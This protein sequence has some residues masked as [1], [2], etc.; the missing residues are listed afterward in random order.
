MKLKK[1][2]SPVSSAASSSPSPIP[3]P[4]K[5]SIT[6]I[7]KAA[8]SIKTA[9]KDKSKV[10]VISDSTPAIPSSTPI[11]AI[12][13]NA[14]L[15]TVTKIPNNIKDDVNSCE[16]IATTELVHSNLGYQIIKKS[17]KGKPQ[18][19]E[20]SKQKKKGKPLRTKTGDRL[21]AGMVDIVFCCDTTGSMSSYLA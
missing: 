16:K 2:A 11:S 14:K 5:K 9:K 10:K 3:S 17:L 19:E 6:P 21:A 15:T 4:K 12:T 13:P 1:V 18:A 20:V 8:S 7:K